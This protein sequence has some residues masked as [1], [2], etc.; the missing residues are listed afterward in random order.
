MKILLF[1]TVAEQS[2]PY[3]KISSPPAHMFAHMLVRDAVQFV[4]ARWIIISPL[5]PH[6]IFC[7][8]FPFIF[9]SP[10]SLASP[11]QAVKQP[12]VIS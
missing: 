5:T 2:V 4:L 11:H 9:A 7:L 6:I 12:F 8:L 3:H 1:Y 10:S